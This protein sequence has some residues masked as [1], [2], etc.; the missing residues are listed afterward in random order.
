MQSG[1]P[2]RE[3]PHHYALKESLK[4]PLTCWLHWSPMCTCSSCSVVF[5]YLRVCLWLLP[6]LF[7]RILG[8]VGGISEDTDECVIGECQSSA[9][10]SPDSSGQSARHLGWKHLPAVGPLDCPSPT[11]LWNSAAPLF[12]GS[13]GCTCLAPV[14]CPSLWPQVPRRPENRGFG[15]P[16]PEEEASAHEP[17]W[18]GKG[19]PTDTPRPRHHAWEAQSQMQQWRELGDQ[20]ICRDPKV[21]GASRQA[22]HVRVHHPALCSPHCL[23]LRKQ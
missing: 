17:S 21:G 8:T 3:K 5:P 23:L 22:A 2:R 6:A 18:K 15:L 4:L 14:G 7:T 1:S 16:A 20:H 13:V 12:G 10:A 11:L 19:D 9:G